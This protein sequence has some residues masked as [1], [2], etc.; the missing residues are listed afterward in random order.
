MSGREQIEADFESLPSS[1][2]ELILLFE[3]DLPPEILDGVRAEELEPRTVFWSL[4]V[5][6]ED[7][8]IDP[9]ALFRKKGII[10]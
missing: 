7:L 5:E 1:A 9:D 8:G 4:W 10:Q 2:E 6:C 3:D